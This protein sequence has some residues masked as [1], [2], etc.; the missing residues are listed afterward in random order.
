MM[1]S[2]RR[3]NSLSR[4][5][6]LLLAI[7]I[8]TGVTSAQEA[9]TET[10]TLRGVV[11]TAAPD[12]QSYNIPGASLKLKHGMQFAETS[13][14]DAGEYEFA[15]LLPG[16]YTLEATAEGFKTSSKTITIRAGETLIENVSL[17]VAE[18]TAS[19]TVASDAAGRADHRNNVRSIP[20][21]RRRCKLCHCQTSSCSTRCRWCLELCVG[22]T[23]RLI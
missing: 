16:E 8:F 14:N 19:V 2:S 1:I 13:A 23:V 4:M 3:Q 6:L 22:Q 5:L 7:M 12:G 9:R 11:A 20:S 15:R 17:E 18:V 21:N 10:G